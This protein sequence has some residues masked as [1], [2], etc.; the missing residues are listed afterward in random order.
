MLLMPH[1]VATTAAIWCSSS[2][3]IGLFLNG[4]LP[5]GKKGE[6]YFAGGIT[7]RTGKGFG[8]NRVP[9]NRAQQ[10]LNAD[11]SLYYADGFLPA[12]ESTIGDQSLIVGYKT[13]L[14]AWNMDLSNTYGH[15]SFAFTVS[16]SG[17]STLPNGTVQTSFD[18]GTLQFSQNTT[19][20][21]FSRLYEKLGAF[22][23]FNVAFG[24][25]LRQDHYQI[26]AGE[27]NSYSGVVKVV[28]QA[29]LSIGTPT[30]LTVAALPGAQVF[31][32]FQPSNEVDK[33]RTNTALYGDLE[34][35]LFNRL[36]LGAAARYENY[37]DFGSNLSWK[38][39]GR[40]KVTEAIALRS[41]VSTGFRAPS[42][43]QRY[44]NN[45]S[46][47]FVSGNPSNTLTVN[48]DNDIARKVIGV[49]ALRPETSQSMTLGITAKLG[50][51]ITA[52]IDAYQIEIKDRIVYSG[53]FSRSLLGFA[54][55]DYVGVNNVNFF[56][57]A[58]NT[59]T[60]GIDMVFN[61]KKIKV[62]KGTLTLT[63]AIN[64]N[65]N[66]VTGIN[67]TTLINS[68]AKNDPTKSPDTWF[69][70]LLFDRQQRSRIEVWQ[71][72]NK[73]NLSATYSVGK[74]DLTLRVVRFGEVQY[75]HNLDTE[76]KK[77]DG[78]F[79]NTQ[80][81]RDASGKAYID[82]TF[83]PMT[84]TDFI[85]GYRI[86]K[87]ISAHVGA[88]NIFDVYPDQIYIDPRNAYGTLDYSSGRDASN[89]GRLL[90]QPNQGGYNGRFIFARLNVSL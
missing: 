40:L 22:K 35:E 75:I 19:N 56:A 11:G 12:I 47:Q 86:N 39:S 51:A 70:N 63:A 64:F 67:S 42:L 28:P 13:Q 88:N 7:H 17:N 69:K 76:A 62:G 23:A 82:Q 84:V 54:A 61:T 73:V 27:L 81:S 32:G 44:F 83:S 30:N 33:T 36:L 77:A 52:T 90:F 80:F 85:V 53:A 89:R 41:S 29:P 48:N 21:D 25:E 49:D 72:K 26:G 2:R 74:L 66:E 15:N 68:D 34:G 58:A 38:L 9:V 31:P 8:N 46:T 1:N 59:R 71:P 57:N 45:I 50:N 37:S 79:W 5:L 16:N 18:A 4:T 3:N 55:T 6:L 20:L 10:P 14:G 78:T 24:A 43:H 65:K 87:M 60:Q